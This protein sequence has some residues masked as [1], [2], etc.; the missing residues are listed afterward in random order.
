[1]SGSGAA[2]VG[3]SL[4][5][6]EVY[7]A[8]TY[9]FKELQ[10]PDERA[11][12]D[13][14]IIGFPTQ[15]P[16][17]ARATTNYYKV[18]V[19]VHDANSGEKLFSRGPLKSGPVFGD[20][21]TREGASTIIQMPD[22]PIKITTVGWHFDWRWSKFGE[23]SGTINLKSE[24]PPPP[25]PPNGDGE[26]FDLMEWLKGEQWGFKRWQLVGGGLAGLIVLDTAR[27]EENKPTIITTGKGG[28]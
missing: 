10:I 27:G 13:D 11:K 17:W 2:G 15:P 21:K 5:E 24:Q 20:W 8:V 14:V 22:T 9:S 12:G 7:G 25:P 1:M 4:P 26:E 23:K 3:E 18:R 19:D 16:I 28:K 6:G